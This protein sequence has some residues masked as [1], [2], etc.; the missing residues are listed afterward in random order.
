MIEINNTTKQKV[1]QLKL[2][3]LA[4]KFLERYRKKGFEVSIAFVG[5]GKMKTLNND[6]RGINKTTDVLSFAGEG[7][8]LGEV[9]INLQE[10]A[11]LPKYQEIISPLLGRLTKELVVSFLLVHGLLHLVGYDDEKEAARLKMISLGTD[12]LK[13]FSL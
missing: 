2:S 9:V 13:K 1:N 11:R 4:A 8:Y 3:H 5:D 12:F 10:A 6:Y 7:K